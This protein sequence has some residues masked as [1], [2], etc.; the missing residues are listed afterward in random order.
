M[1]NFHRRRNILWIRVFSFWLACP[2][3]SYPVGGY[4]FQ[5][6]GTQGSAIPWR[7]QTA[8]SRGTCFTLPASVHGGR[9]SGKGCLYHFLAHTIPSGFRSSS[10]GLLSPSGILAG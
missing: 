3:E 4:S 2:R 5:L 6:T 7:I 10:T 1:G 9:I 8:G